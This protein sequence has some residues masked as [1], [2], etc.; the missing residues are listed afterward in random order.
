MHALFHVN[1]SANEMHVC[2]CVTVSTCNAVGHPR[3]E[4]MIRRLVLHHQP[5][6]LLEA[7]AAGDIDAVKAMLSHLPPMPNVSL[8]S[9][10]LSL[11]SAISRHILP[12]RQ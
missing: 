8:L 2:L 6:N 4:Q 10:Y 1:V 7:V 3:L 5:N 9:S 12:W 11:V